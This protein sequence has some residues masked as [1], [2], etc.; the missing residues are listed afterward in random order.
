MARLRYLTESDLEPA[1]QELLARKLN[2]YRILAHSPD[3]TRSLR[4]PALYI[5][6]HS[7]LDP[8]LRELA[9]VQVGFVSKI[10]Y[11][12]AHHIEIGREFGVT[13]D[14][15]R[16]I[17]LESAG[18][19]S[20]LPALDRAILSAARELAAQPAL[21]EETFAIL[22]AALSDAHVVDL[23][24]AIGLYCGVVRILGALQIELEPEY[25]ALLVKFPLP[26]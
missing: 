14:D 26:T 23:V 24:M 6:H 18:T 3:A 10:A 4:T 22:R 16:A 1:D 15:L 11:E 19:P 17:A 8:R 5:R 2:L 9:I 13:D 7:T 21:S 25:A 12:Y 20:G